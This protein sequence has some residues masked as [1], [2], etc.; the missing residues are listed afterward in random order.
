MKLFFRT[1]VVCF[2]LIL[3]S[4]LVVEATPSLNQIQSQ[5]VKAQKAWHKDSVA[6]QGQLLKAYAN[7][8]HWTESRHQPA[9]RER[10]LYLAITCFSHDLVTETALAADNYLKLFPTGRYLH[11]VNIYRAMAAFAIND[12]DRAQQA[13]EDA[14]VAS[15]NK[16]THPQQTMVISGR[17]I[18]GEH[19]SAE[20]FM[21]NQASTRSTSGIKQDLKR[22]NY[23]NRMIEGILKRVAEGKV[24][25]MKAAELIENALPQSYFAKR[26]PEATLKAVKIRD[27]QT[28][29]YNP[30]VTEWCGHER[31]VKHALSPQL[32][33]K[34]YE[35][36]VADF[37]QAP[38]PELFSA[39]MNLRYLYLYEFDDQAKANTMLELMKS[40]N[41]MEE[42]A[43]LEELVSNFSTNHIMSAKGH[44]TLTRI[45]ELA[46]YLPFDN[47]HLP[48]ISIA[49]IRHMLMISD[50][51]MGKSNVTNFIDKNAAYN[52]PVDLLYAAATGNKEEAYKL[53]LASR[54]K[55]TPKVARMVSDL[56]KPLYLTMCAGDRFFAAG[57]LA[58]PH[59]PQVGIL[60]LL[61]SITG[62]ERM[63]KL[64]HGFAVLAEAYNKHRAHAEAQE[65]WAM[66]TQMF[67]DSIWL[68]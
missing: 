5:I 24:S 30:V 39:L 10:A 36:F 17:I 15:G 65:L 25:G 55:F 59:Y 27:T 9:V 64:E 63:R 46:D 14:R 44:E 26:A 50:V 16:L 62:N 31:A 67:P 51:A 32:R 2:G 53:Y 23:G 3:V 60:L 37:P 33:L 56:V 35:G 11:S 4:A 45:I 57:L 28:P 19:R 38:A 41:G 34:K 7:A 13:L 48:V 20:K 8:M 22:M 40:L 21:Q 54:D 6:A 47:G 66:L 61:E 49:M 42:M 12:F 58:L 43:E 29:A 1:L 52:I 18:Q 68:K